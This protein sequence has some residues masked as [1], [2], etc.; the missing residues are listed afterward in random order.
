VPQDDAEAIKWWRKAAEHE[1]ADAQSRLGYAYS[2]GQSV[3]QDDAEA[4]KWWR[5][6]AEHGNANAQHNL[7]YMYANGVGV[8]KDYVKAYMW[9]SL[10]VG[11]YSYGD[12][13]AR[14]RAIANR[15]LFARYMTPQQV[16]EAQS[17]SREWKPTA[18][19]K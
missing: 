6:A 11:R 18:I 13:E 3:P 14:N 4:I 9:T 2:T 7:G 19:Q 12:G 5:K 1:N 10:A 8:P 15:D 17:L 16:S